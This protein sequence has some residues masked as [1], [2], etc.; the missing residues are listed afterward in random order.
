MVS[1]DGSH[2]ARIAMRPWGDDG[3]RQAVGRVFHPFLVWPNVVTLP[4]GWLRL[5][6]SRLT[7]FTRKSTR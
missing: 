2:L 1:I 3:R 4:A 5:V 7:T 6:S